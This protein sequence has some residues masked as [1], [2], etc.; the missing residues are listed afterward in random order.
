[1][2]DRFQIG[3]EHKTA[4]IFAVIYVALG[5]VFEEFYISIFIFCWFVVSIILE[6]LGVEFPLAIYVR[7][8]HLIFIGLIALAKLNVI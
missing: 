1:M 5:I 3:G 8:V 7:C 2:N 4:F 6:R